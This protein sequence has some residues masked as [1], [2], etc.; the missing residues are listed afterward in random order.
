[1]TTIKQLKELLNKFPDDSIIRIKGE[2]GYVPFDIN[3][4]KQWEFIDYS[5]KELSKSSPLFKKKVLFLG[6]E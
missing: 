6:E 1:M 5:T 4:E 2:E 3:N